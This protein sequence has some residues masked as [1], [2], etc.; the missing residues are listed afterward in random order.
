MLKIEELK[1]GNYL[2]WANNQITQVERL[3]KGESTGDII[4]NRGSND[5]FTPIPLTEQWL[6]DF[7]FTGTHPKYTLGDIMIHWNDYIELY[8]YGQ[9]IRRIEF[10]H[11][12]QNICYWLTGE[13]L[14]ISP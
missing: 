10:V 3:V 2:Y 12:I 8:F 11:E 7:Q 9:Y 4:I 13:E 14:K 6:L 1:I 5:M